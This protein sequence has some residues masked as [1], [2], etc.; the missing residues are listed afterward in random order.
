MIGIIAAALFFGCIAFLGSYA[1]NIICAGITP[2]VD[3][4]PRGKPPVAFLIGASALLGALIV[5]RG[6]SQLQIAIVSIVVFACVA[7]WCS[8]MICGIVP[9]AFTLAPLGAL[10][11][12]ALTHRDWMIF[13]WAIIPF[14]PFAFA[15]FL[16]HGTGMG[17]GDAKLVAL[18]GAV[19]GAPLALLMMAA[20]CLAALVGYRLKGIR[21]GPIAFAPYIAAFIG[22][23]VALPAGLIR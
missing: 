1:S 5:A 2:P 19:L 3:G 7:S 18:A 15:A 22:I 17:W 20:A 14:V 4:P 23:G 10:L 16:S 9:D 8:D 12:F 11:L 13:L 6:G 21:Q